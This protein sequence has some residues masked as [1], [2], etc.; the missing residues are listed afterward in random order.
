MERVEKPS[1]LGPPIESGSSVSSLPQNDANETHGGI[2]SLDLSSLAGEDHEAGLVGGQTLGVDLE[3][4]LTLVPPAVVDGN[5]DAEGLL[6][7]DSCSLKLLVGEATS[8]AE[9]GVVA[10]RGATDG[11]AE[12]LSGPGEGRVEESRWRG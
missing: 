2:S 4:L 1:A 8:G 10:L 7:A 9:L 5:A 12:E 3:S 6:A 11:G